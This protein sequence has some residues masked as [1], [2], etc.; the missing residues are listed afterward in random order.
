MDKSMS[1]M[2]DSLS[3]DLRNRYIRNMVAEG[4]EGVAQKQDASR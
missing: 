3:E 4:K 1:E 2:R